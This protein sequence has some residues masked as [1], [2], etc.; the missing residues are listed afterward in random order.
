MQ[1]LFILH[2]QAPIQKYLQM[3]PFG[4]ARKSE[5]CALF[6]PQ[7]RKSIIVCI[8]SHL[9]C[10]TDWKPPWS[11]WSDLITYSSCFKFWTYETST[12]YCYSFSLLYYSCYHNQPSIILINSKMISNKLIKMQPK[13]NALIKQKILSY[14]KFVCL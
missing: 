13:P 8:V 9:L 6:K 4:I 1:V 3:Q 14:L 12:F 10:V 2:F 5:Q 11:N 7:N